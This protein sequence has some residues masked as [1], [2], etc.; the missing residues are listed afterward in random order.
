[1]PQVK[2]PKCVN[3]ESPREATGVYAHSGPFA[4]QPHRCKF[5]PLAAPFRPS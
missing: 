5:V 2:T 4:R 3:Q 1:M